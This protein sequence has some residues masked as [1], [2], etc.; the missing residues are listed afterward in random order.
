MQQ[1][2]RGSN[3]IPIDNNMTLS[4]IMGNNHVHQEQM[5]KTNELYNQL[6]QSIKD[7]VGKRDG[8]KLKVP[9][10]KVKAAKP[11]PIAPSP[12]VNPKV[13]KVPTS[14]KEALILKIQKYQDSKRFGSFI[15]KDLKIIQ[16]RE[17][18][19][20][21]S[22]SKLEN[23]LHRI[24]LNLNNRNLSAIF[25]NM[26]LTC[27]AGYETTLTEL[28]T[29]NPGFW[30]AFERW[31]IERE[32][33]NIPP[34]IQLG[35]IVASTTIAAHSLNASQQHIKTEDER[36]PSRS[37]AEQ[38]KPKEMVIIDSDDKFTVGKKI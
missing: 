5:T 38:K 30:D 26:A 23:I 34:G 16:T 12:I 2:K 6:S 21:L 31:Q 28:L 17:Q 1:S 25:E 36:Q 8:K 19:A 22:P 11:T 33:P 18:L 10:A 20:R 24:R 4:S 3:I 13:P 14:D 7:S 35:Y 15:K 37:S 29:A 9:K 32:M 27:A